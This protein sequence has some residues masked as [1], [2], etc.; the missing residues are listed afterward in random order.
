MMRSAVALQFYDLR[1]AHFSP[2]VTSG[3]EIA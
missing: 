3:D 1:A 2:Y